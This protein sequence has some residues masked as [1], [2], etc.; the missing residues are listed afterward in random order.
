M[1][2]FD[3]F[4]PKDKSRQLLLDLISHNVDIIERDEGKSRS[5][6]EY[7]AICLIIDDLR[8]RPNGREGYMQ[9]I[10]ILQSE[11]DSH[12]NDIMTYVAWST[13]KIILKPEGEAA[14]RA[15]HAK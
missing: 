7:L 9:V 1:G 11:Y 10:D 5:E 15:R 14:M 6:A 2:L 13:G 12:L 8:K 4:K 3:F